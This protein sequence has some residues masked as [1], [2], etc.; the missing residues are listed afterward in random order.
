MSLRSAA[1]FLIPIG[2]TIIGWFAVPIIKAKMDGTTLNR[3]P[4]MLSFWKH[5]ITAPL[6]VW[7]VFLLTLAAAGISVFAL[8]K[9][10]RKANLSIIVLPHMEPRWGIG[11]MRTT[12]FMSI[13]FLVRFTTTEEHSLEIVKCYLKGTTPVMLFT[14]VI[15]SGRYDEPTMVHFAVRPILAK[16]GEKFT[17]RVIF[18]DQYK[19]KHLTEKLTFSDNPLPP[20]SFGFGRSTAVNCLIC[21]KEIALEDIHPSASF[22]AHRQCVK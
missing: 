15:V 4:G 11:A 22:P 1:K 13:H 19:S 16:P 8:K 10:K 17:A 21:R 5:V 6:P 3:L 14:Q 7:G 20:E 2:V 18:V 9:R 12:P